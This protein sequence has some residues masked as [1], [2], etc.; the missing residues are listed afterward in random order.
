MFENRLRELVCITILPQLS[1]PPQSAVV[2][3]IAAVDLSASGLTAEFAA[4]DV[5]EAMPS[6]TFE[7]L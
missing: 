6:V 4:N 1:L 5:A 2:I 3:R 7:P